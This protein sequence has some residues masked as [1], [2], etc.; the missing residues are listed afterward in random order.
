MGAYITY[1]IAALVIGYI[2]YNF[3][4]VRKGM[5]QPPSENL[6]ILTDANFD[7]SISKG[8]SL[9]DFWAAWCGP[10]K[11]VGPIINEL[12]DEIKGKANICKVD[13]DKNQATAQK[14]GIQSIPTILIFKDGKQVDKLVGVKPKRVL[15]K[16]VAIAY[17]NKQYGKY[18]NQTK[19]IFK[20]KAI[21]PSFGP[22][23]NWAYYWC[24]RRLYLLLTNRMCFRHLRHHFKPLDEYC[25]GR[26]IWISCI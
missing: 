11:V 8:V 17:I 26:C 1:I 21:R 16:A 7:K 6:K 23:F 13:I 20:E 18:G 14:Y 5:N 25:L 15:L 4:K 12:A 19:H 3:L 24:N 9:V 2:F 22:Y 10:C